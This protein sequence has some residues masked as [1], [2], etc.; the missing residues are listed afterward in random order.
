MFM[1]KIFWLLLIISQVNAYAQVMFLNSSGLKVEIKN[2]EVANLRSRNIQWDE[3]NS[4]DVITFA[5]LK[6]DLKITDVGCGLADNSELFIDYKD[7]KTG[8]ANSTSKTRELNFYL[9]RNDASD[10]GCTFES[11]IE[12][13][14]TIY[15]PLVNGVGDGAD[16]DIIY[17][18]VIN[19][20]AGW[21]NQPVELIVKVNQRDNLIKLN[22]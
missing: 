21:G 10:Y 7:S 16:Q 13:L 11:E 15:L 12:K 9:S 4:Y 6:I 20:N 22:P 19:A 2:A 14:E 8:S 17:K 18:Y 3:T 5:E 1:K